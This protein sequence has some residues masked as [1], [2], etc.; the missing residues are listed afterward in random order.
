MRRAAEASL[1]PLHQDSQERQDP[2]DERDDTDD[3][4]VAANRCPGARE[5]IADA[6]HSTERRHREDETGENERD[7]EDAQQIQDAEDEGDDADHDLQ[8]AE[9]TDDARTGFAA[10]TVIEEEQTGDDGDEGGED[11]ELR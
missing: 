7:A 9:R 10:D 6:R 8:G 3:V 2:D 5:V 4:A 11:G 1:T